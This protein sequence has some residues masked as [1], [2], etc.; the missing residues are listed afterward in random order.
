MCFSICSFVRMNLA[1]AQC[2]PWTWY[3]AVEWQLHVVTPPVL[4]LLQR[5]TRWGVF[6]VACLVTLSCVTCGVLS[7]VYNLPLTPHVPVANVT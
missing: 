2:M 5:W 7:H 6:L 4:I 3:L 1:H